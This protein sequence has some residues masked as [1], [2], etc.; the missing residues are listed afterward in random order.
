LFKKG[1]KNEQKTNNNINNNLIYMVVCRMGK[2]RVKDQH[3]KQIT[4]KAQR[5]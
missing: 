3:E 5:L 2:I 1:N 4:T